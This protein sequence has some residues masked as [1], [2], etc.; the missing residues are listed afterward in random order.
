MVATVAEAE[1]EAMLATGMDG[2]REIAPGEFYKQRRE[3]RGCV[4]R[5]K[6]R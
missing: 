3:R 2:A 1:V 4:W 6:W 5:E